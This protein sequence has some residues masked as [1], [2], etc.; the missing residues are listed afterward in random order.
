MEVLKVSTMSNPA[1]ATFRLEKLVNRLSGYVQFEEMSQAIEQMIQ[2]L[3]NKLCEEKNKHFGV[4]YREKE[5]R[6]KVAKLKK[7]NNEYYHRNKR[8]AETIRYSSALK[9]TPGDH[10]LPDK[11][12]HLPTYAMLQR[13][14]HPLSERERVFLKR[15]RH[16][17]SAKDHNFTL[18]H[19][20]SE[21]SNTYG[22]TIS[23]R[24][25]VVAATVIQW[26][27]TN[28]GQCFLE[29]CQKEIAKKRKKANNG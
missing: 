27:G 26:L 9:R 15:W 19:I 20:M 14:K 21:D 25:A 7:D 24:D 8:L 12:R 10:M 17:N 13:A 23:Q 22:A 28:C 3:N 6:E 5:L 2:D 11:V 1:S 18:R 16:E 29:M 4:D